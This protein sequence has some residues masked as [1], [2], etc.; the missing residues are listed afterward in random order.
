ME[1]EIFIKSYRFTE[2]KFRYSLYRERITILIIIY[3]KGHIVIPYV[4]S[5]LFISKI[6][7]NKHGSRTVRWRHIC[8]VPSEIQVSFNVSSL[9]MYTRVFPSKYSHV[10]VRALEG[11][12]AP[13][14]MHN[15]YAFLSLSCCTTVQ[16]RVWG[17]NGTAR[18]R[19]REIERERER[20]NAFVNSTCTNTLVLV[21][22][23]IEYQRDSARG[24]NSALILAT[25][26]AISI[27][28]LL[29]AREESR[30]NKIEK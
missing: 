29:F 27:A 13:C 16:S 7:I 15:K 18:A 12:T 26:R 23:T 1:W 24:E 3:M 28:S 22:G 9:L 8:F 25:T 17:K 6:T 21:S 14:G 10:F 2:K 19:E 5:L 4:T 11:N 30:R 20:E